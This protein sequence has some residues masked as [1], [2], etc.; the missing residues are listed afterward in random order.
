MEE[1]PLK[2]PQNK[3]ARISQISP[4]NNNKIIDQSYNEE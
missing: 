4:K 2:K 3:T 1:E